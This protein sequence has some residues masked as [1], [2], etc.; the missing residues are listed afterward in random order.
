MSGTIEGSAM[1]CEFCEVHFNSEQ[2]KVQH[3]QSPKHFKKKQNKQSSGGIYA[4]PVE[5]FTQ[6]LAD[7]FLLPNL[8]FACWIS[9]KFYLKYKIVC[10][11]FLKMSTGTEIV[12]KRWGLE[13]SF[14]L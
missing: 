10:R 6:L 4:G 12:T 13:K 9:A 14:D 2:Q 11:I 5:I 3:L 1:Y 7:N 8:P